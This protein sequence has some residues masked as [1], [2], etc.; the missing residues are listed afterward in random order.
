[1]PKNAKK[2]K[3]NATNKKNNQNPKVAPEPP[4]HHHLADHNN[5]QYLAPLTAPH[6]TPHVAPLPTTLT[7]KSRRTKTKK[8]MMKKKTKKVRKTATA[9]AQPTPKKRDTPTNPC[10][11]NTSD[12]N[13]TYPVVAQ[14]VAQILQGEAN[15]NMVKRSG[16]N[17]E[18]KSSLEG[19]I[20]KAK[21][22]NGA[23]PSNLKDTCS[24]TKEYTN[25]SR[26]TTKDGPCE[27]KNTN[28]FNLREKWKTGKKVSSKDRVFLPPRREHMCTS[29]LEYLQTNISPLNG[30]GNGGVDIVNH[31]FLGDVLLSAKY[32]ADFIK[33][34][35][36]RLN[37]QNDKATVCRAIK[38]SFAD[39]GD[40]IKGTD[41]WDK[42]SGEE[43]TQNKLV[44]VFEKIKEELDDKYIGDKAKPPYRQ[45]RADWWEANR[46]KVWEAMKCP[47]NGIKC[48]NGETPLDDYIP[49]RLRWMT[50]WAEWFCK[51]QSQEYKELP[52]GCESFMSK[53]NVRKNCN[54]QTEEC[55][56]CKAACKKYTTEI[57][58]WEKQW[59]KIKA[60]YE[61]LYRQ[62]K[63][64]STNRGPTGFNDGR[65]DYQQV[66]HF[67]EVLQKQNSG[68]TTYD[69]A[70]GYIHQEARVGDC[71]E[72]NEFCEKENGNDDA[73]DCMI[74]KLE[75]KVTS[76]LSSTSGDNLAQCENST[77]AED[78]DD[79]GLP[80]KR[81]TRT[82]PCYSDATTEYDMLAEKVA[83]E[84][85]GDAHERVKTINGLIADASQGHYSRGGDTQDFK[86]ICKIT[87]NHTNA[88]DS[89]HYKY[90]GPCGGKD[91][92][93]EMFKLE[94]VWK[95]G[96]EVSEKHK[97]LFLPPRREH[98]CTSNLENLDINSKGLI[99]ANASHSLLGDVL[100]AACKQAEYITDKY[101][102]R[103]NPQEF[104]NEATICR[105]IKYSFADLGDII[106]GTDLWVDEDGE[107]RTQNNLESI[108]KNIKDNLPDGFKENPQYTEKSSPPYKQLRSDWWEANRAKV[109]DAMQCAT[110]PA[111]INTKCGTDTPLMDYIPQRLRWMTEWAEW[112]C[113]YQ[114]Q[115]YE[116][117]QKQCGKCTGTNKDN[118]T[119]DNHDC[120][121]CKNACDKYTVN[122]EKWEKQWNTISK[123][124]EELYEQAKTT[125]TNRG[126]TGFNDGRPD[127]KQVVD[128]FKKLKETIKSS[129][130]KRQKRSLP[131]DTSTPYSSA[132]G[133][134]HQ[135]L[136]HT[137]CQ[138]QK[139][140]CTSGD[141]EDKDYVFRENPKDHDEACGCNERNPKPQPP[142]G[143]PPAITSQEEEEDEEEEE[144]EEE[145][146]DGE[147]ADEAK[148]LEEEEEQTPEEDRKGKDGPEETTEQDPP[149]DTADEAKE[150]EEEKGP[151]D[152]VKPC[153]IVDKLFTNG[154][155]TA[156]K[157]AC[158][159]KYGPGGKEKFP[160][161]KCVSS[162]N[163]SETTGSSGAETATTGKPTKS[164]AT[165]GGSIC[166]P[167]R[168][169]KLYVGHLEKWANSGNTQVATQPQSQSTV[170]VSQGEPTP[171]LTSPSPSN[172]RDVDL[173]NAFVKSAAV[174]TFFLWHKYK[175]E[176]TKRQS[177]S[178]LLQPGAVSVEQ[179]PEQQL[180]KGIIPDEFKRQM[181]YTLADYKDIL[182]SGSN[183]TTSVSK[184]TS[185]SSNDNLKHIVLEASGDKQ[186]EMK[187]IQKKI[188]ETLE[189]GSTEGSGPQNSDKDR[190]SLWDKIAQPI[191]NGMI[192]ALTYNTD[193]PSG[194]TSITQDT[195][196]K[197]QLLENGKQ[198]KKN[199]KYNYNTVKLDDTSGPKTSE[200][201]INTPTLKEFI[202][203]PP[204][205]RYLEEWGEN[206][207]KERKKRLEEIY[208]DCRGGEN[209][210]KVCSGYGED[211]QKML[212]ADPSN[213]PSLECPDCGKYCSSY[214]KWIVRKKEE[215]DKQK[216]RY[217]KE[218]KSAEGNSGIYGPM[219]VTELEKYGS[220][221]VFLQKLNGGPCKTNKENGEDNQKDKLDFTK[222]DVTF[223]HAENC[224]PCSKFTVECNGN[225][226]CKGDTEN[227]CN[228]GKIS[229]ENIN[230][231]TD[232]N[233]LVSDKSGNGFQNGL[234]E[235]KDKGIFE[236][237]REDVWT[238]G[239]VCG[240][241]V[242]KPKKV[243]GETTSGEN[244]DQIITIR[245]L[246]AHWVHNFLE[247]YNKI[248]HKI[249]H[250]TKTDQRSTCIKGC[251][252]K[253]VEEK[254]KEWENI[255]KR[256]LEQYKNNEQNDYNMRS[257]LEELIPQIPVANAKNK[258]IKLSVFENSKGC[259]VEAHSQKNDGYQDAIECLLDKLGEKAKN[260]PGKPS[261]QNPE[262]PCD[263]TP[264][265]DDDEPLEETENPENK[266]GHP[267]ICEG[268]V[269]TTEPEEPGE[270]CTPAAAGGG[271]G[272]EE[273][274]SPLPEETPAAPPPPP[275]PPTQADEPF[276]RDIL[277]KTIPF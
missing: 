14:T 32:E 134:I 88:E 227:E 200:D 223:K 113:K 153:Q 40:I 145:G 98:F 7:P 225:G 210:N 266:V 273:L 240:Y 128:F 62:A 184:G 185:S 199:G 165:T 234:N 24:I 255:K 157:E 224:K 269:Q 99:D 133:Y 196:L 167:P 23:K 221:G 194:Q 121:T 159:Q 238:C 59:N 18:T 257:F 272:T 209:G 108:F 177:G 57:Q 251:V 166:V 100:L 276:N 50:E 192:C 73:I 232:I 5:Q 11:G 164:G 195:N 126:P 46:A 123:K 3:M 249:S 229:A 34:N 182:Y 38:Y 132:A 31:S 152:N 106:K 142:P 84:I 201:T 69:T 160:N 188:K 270:T 275:V 139:H 27:G 244:N 47:K 248:K 260:C 162:G 228:G 143:G 263:T 254:K 42:N 268:V 158:R 72:Q 76:C 116:T 187:K 239:K 190:Q 109:W 135:E 267:Q 253:W 183:D 173:R 233:M 102:R 256:F 33:N 63:T 186:D 43:T 54:K 103:N 26:G 151:K 175:A 178:Q 236:G 6:A 81:D 51:M 10:S 25:D 8:M 252:E 274:P 215:F 111:V 105:A 171:A 80:K 95:S 242:C 122:I 28:R 138:I 94:N 4:H 13:A 212:D 258:V 85:Q 19:D 241:N 90:D 179:T 208:K 37:G 74:K 130:S 93:G 203:R 169:R 170:A 55:E 172:P 154:D 58:K 49:Q 86:D 64:T 141:K 120:N 237:I 180:K 96:A 107:K 115:E 202:S 87:E 198:P 20:S 35:Y 61:E 146:E 277:E 118:C 66:V 41:L 52:T 214:K 44:Q 119:R 245:G 68:K 150:Q 65:P 2:L 56:K 155:T 207:C 222:A 137:Q 12:A 104:K 45:L 30:A 161:W 246:V 1:M 39:I 71:D 156:L 204:Y 131:R 163:T 92:G 97:G 53:G 140:F 250:C 176:N 231:S 148:E 189:S 205:F 217:Q 67:F 112:Y 114:S 91:G 110:K 79:D 101:N 60:K 144:E 15:K 264:L 77:L 89:Y 193:T 136:P 226:N 149:A 125:S 174:E 235:C 70:A 127:Y 75:E 243:N 36:T 271:E 129:A 261:G 124:Y 181:F 219:F 22:K 16:K 48:D 83:K 197:E 230:N 82:N 216:D 21:F 206:F 213:F 117:L 262:T 259:C 78:E 9:K 147:D 220:I 17:G 191:W 168:R 265:E 211:C 218:S 29:N 247:D